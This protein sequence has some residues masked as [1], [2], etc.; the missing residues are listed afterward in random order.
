MN[1]GNSYDTGYEIEDTATTCPESMHL[2]E[3]FGF[4]EIVVHG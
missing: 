2:L 4:E 3:T 1:R